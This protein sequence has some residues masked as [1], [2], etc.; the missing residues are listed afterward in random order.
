MHLNRINIYIILPSELCTLTHAFGTWLPP[1]VVHRS[2]K[3]A[4]VLV[5]CVDEHSFVKSNGVNTIIIRVYARQ[6][7]NFRVPSENSGFSVGV[8]DGN[9]YSSYYN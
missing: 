3:H 7:S 8:L 9:Q 6:T 4:L 5:D 2:N 1:Y